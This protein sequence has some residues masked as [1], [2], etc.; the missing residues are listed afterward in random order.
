ME[1]KTFNRPARANTFCG[2]AVVSFLTGIDTG[3]AAA[4]I[5]RRTGLRSVKGTNAHEIIGTLEA[6]GIEAKYMP[7]GKAKAPTL[8]RW[9]A[10][11]KEIRTAGRM[12]LIAAGHHWQLVSGRRYACG[13]VGEVC[14]IRDK[15][16]KRRAR[17]TG[18]WELRGTPRVSEPLKPVR[19]EAKRTR[20]RSSQ[21][22]SARRRCKELAA[23][24]IVS[25]DLTDRR[26][27]G[28]IWVLPGANFKRPDGTDID[29]PHEGDHIVY[30][31]QEAVQ[32]AEVY[33]ELHESA[34]RRAAA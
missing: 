8:A 21:E 34:H 10:D 19:A 31:W 27:H 33:A 2:P 12:Y 30:D 7:S 26:R 25:L 16:V 18:V 3:E 32:C 11:S 24:G 4:L 14:S 17:V 28:H 5:R 23:A 20:A 9:L 22:S 29:D 13:R 15:R 1:F 6:L